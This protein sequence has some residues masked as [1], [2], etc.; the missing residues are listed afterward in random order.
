MELEEDLE[1]LN[2]PMLRLPKDAGILVTDYDTLMIFGGKPGIKEPKS[3]HCYEVF[4]TNE[5]R[6]LK[7]ERFK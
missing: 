6:M 5:S 4:L 7:S 1:L 2:T 3:K